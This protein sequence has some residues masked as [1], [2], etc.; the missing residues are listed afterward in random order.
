LLQSDRLGFFTRIESAADDVLLNYLRRFRTELIGDRLSRMEWDERFR[1]VAE[2]LVLGRNDT[3]KAIESLPGLRTT[4]RLEVYRRLLK[5]RD[6][7]LSSLSEPIGLKDIAAAACLS[8]FHFHRSFTRAFGETPH[9]YLT[10]HRL[11]RAA[12]LL[13]RTE[14]SVTEICLNS[15]FESLTSFIDLFRRHFG[16]SPGKFSKI[17]EA[18][19]PIRL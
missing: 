10:R 18:E 8:P 6:F 4:T 7:L 9:R 11:Q 2:M 15:G 13:S 17:K 1:R 3:L 16:V 5:G 14:S 19:H 12:R